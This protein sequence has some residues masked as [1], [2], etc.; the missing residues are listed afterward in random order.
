MGQEGLRQ[1]IAIA[2]EQKY[3]RHVCLFVGRSGLKE[4]IVKGNPIDGF[5][6]KQHQKKQRHGHD[7]LEEEMVNRRYAKALKKA[8]N[9]PDNQGGKQVEKQCLEVEERNC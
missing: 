6:R 4:E 3:V 8:I 9:G 7:C 2:K 5:P 1:G